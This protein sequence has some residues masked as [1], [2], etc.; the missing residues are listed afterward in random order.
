MTLPEIDSEVELLIG[1]N[2]PRVMEPIQV[3]C[4]VNNGP[5]AIQTSLGWTVNG[6]LR[7]DG[8]DQST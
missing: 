7:G 2:A 5:Y 1:I 8:G 6:P 4:S 3:I